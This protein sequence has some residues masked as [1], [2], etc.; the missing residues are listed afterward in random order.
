MHGR[1]DKQ[2]RSDESVSQ[3]TG[4]RYLILPFLIVIV[5]AV[6]AAFRPPTSNWIAEAVQAEMG[7]VAMVPSDSAPAQLAQP[8]APDSG[9][10]DLTGG[11]QTAQ[12]RQR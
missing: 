10:G 11:V 2:G 8:A 3:D 7:S 6:L 4:L 5:L 1:F 9:T 12:R